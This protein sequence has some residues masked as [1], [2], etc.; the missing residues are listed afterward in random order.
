MTKTAYYTTLVNSHSCYPLITHE[1][2]EIIDKNLPHKHGV[3][4]CYFIYSHFGQIK[5]FSY[6][7]H[8]R[9]W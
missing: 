4:C 2:N 1:N 7:M 9:N 5:N 3:K 6:F 8:G